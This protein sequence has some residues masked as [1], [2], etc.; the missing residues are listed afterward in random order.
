MITFP[1]GA[2]S[3]L[4]VRGG[5]WPLG[6]NLASSA[7]AIVANG[8]T[9][10]IQA[11]RLGLS[12][13]D[14]ELFA[15]LP[16]WTADANSMG[17]KFIRFDVA[18][19]VVQPVD[20]G[21]FDW[22][23]SDALFAAMPAGMEPF[24]IL[25]P[26]GHLDYSFDTPAE[27]TA[28]ANFA[29]AVVSRYPQLKYIE[30]GNEVNLDAR[31]TPANYAAMLATCYPA[32]KAVRS[33]VQVGG[34]ALSGAEITSG[35]T[36]SVSDYVTG[37]YAA[38]AKNFFDFLSLHAYAPNLRWLEPGD[39]V[40][41]SRQ[42]ILEAR[43]IMVANG[44]SNKLIWM[45]EIGADTGGTVY[46]PHT[47]ASA[48]RFVREVYDDLSTRDYIGPVFWYSYQDRN[49]GS[50]QNEDNFGLRTSAGLRKFAYEEFKLRALRDAGFTRTFRKNSGVQR[51]QLRRFFSL[52][53]DPRL[54]T[55][56]ISTSSLPT[57]FTLSGQEL[58]IDTNTAALQA[59]IPIIITASRAGST[60]ASITL[61]VTITNPEQVANAA[62]TSATGW[63]V[64]N[65]GA[66]ISYDAN[67]DA[68][69]LNATTS[70]IGALLTE[71]LTLNVGSVYRIRAW[72]KAG[73]YTGGVNLGVEGNKID[74]GALTGEYREITRTFT[75]ASASPYLYIDQTSSAT[76]T[77][78][79]KSYSIELANDITY[80]G[81][82]GAQASSVTLPAHQAGDLMVF[83]ASQGN[84]I[85]NV[86]QL[87]TD[88][89]SLL[90]VQANGAC[91]RVGYKYAQSSSETSGI[92]TGAQF[93]SCAIFRGNISPGAI[94]A[95]TGNSTT[96]TDP[97]LTLQTADGSSAVLAMAFIRGNVALPLRATP[98]MT[99]VYHKDT[100][101]SR[102]S[103]QQVL[104]QASWSQL[105]RTTLG[106]SSSGHHMVA[107][108]LRNFIP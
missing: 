97:G 105:A 26:G 100:S 27:R 72:V 108:E 13:P 51:V 57:G 59:G 23:R 50:A 80:V 74:V 39:P 36:T 55:V 73:T 24:V 11:A 3:R 33:T 44:D 77:F 47:Q 83:F 102:M 53:G 94:A 9:S 14:G 107:L 82:A 85:T 29:A 21:A 48:E 104:D 96:I 45:T 15:G 46:T 64:T 49:T 10:G 56:T 91:T 58:V 89:Q 5:R 31:T 92:W 61:T 2:N 17:I 38:G 84:D 19:S 41:H 90:V 79:I 75:A 99:T 28:F 60:S 32:I 69:V 71:T 103:V 12:I 25:A 65:T 63:W 87:P 34:P 43:N 42:R 37:I 95:L 88:C 67:E 68:L 86:P 16:S 70:F 20:G 52:A 76:G 18:K 62:V 7:A 35:N 98:T 54:S 4:R 66:T 81:G 78:F 22:T 1:I 93:V 40:W 101:F 30:L 106:G 8:I 6:L